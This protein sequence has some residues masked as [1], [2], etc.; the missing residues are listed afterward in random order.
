MNSSSNVMQLFDSKKCSACGEVKMLSEFNHNVGRHG[1]VSLTANCLPCRQI[2]KKATWQAKRDAGE[3]FLIENDGRSKVVLIEGGRV[4][5]VC[6]EGK[7]W[8]QFPNDKHGY[9]GKQARCRKCEKATRKPDIRSHKLSDY[10]ARIKRTY[11]VTW[12]HVVKVLADQHGR[13]A[14]KACGKEISLYVPNGADRANI[15]HDHKTGKFRALLCVG[16]NTLAGKLEN[17][18]HIVDGIMDYLTKFR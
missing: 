7:V 1:K 8:D 14:N 6:N 5:L 4:C 15:D 12:E 17:R 10:P 18:Q 11:G 16:C 3:K 13:C 9:N 2:K